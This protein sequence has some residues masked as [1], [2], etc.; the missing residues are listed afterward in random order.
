MKRHA[1][2]RRE[3]TNLTTSIGNSCGEH[4]RTRCVQKL[5][6][7]REGT[8][9]IARGERLSLNTT[10]VDSQ[11]WSTNPEPDKEY[12]GRVNELIAQVRPDPW[13][14]HAASIGSGCGRAQRRVL[15]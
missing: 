9:A 10:E 8:E 14:V 1:R 4:I 11:W 15:H 2:E 6:D 7:L 3:L 12:Q 13:H 5:K